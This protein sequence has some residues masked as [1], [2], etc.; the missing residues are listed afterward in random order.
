MNPSSISR[1]VRFPRLEI[2]Y[3]KTLSTNKPCCGRRENDEK[4]KRIYIRD[5]TGQLFS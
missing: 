4:N 2:V 1:F 5:R 3:G